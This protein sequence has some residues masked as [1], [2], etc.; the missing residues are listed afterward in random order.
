GVYPMDGYGQH[1]Y[2][3]GWELAPIADI[4]NCISNYHGFYVAYEGTGTSKG[5]WVTEFGWD[6]NY[7]QQRNPTWSWAKCLSVQGSNMTTSLN[8][9]NTQ[10]AGSYVKFASWYNWQDGGGAD[11]GLF[12][13][14]G[15]PTPA[16]TNF[17]N[18]AHYE[19]RTAINNGGTDTAILNYY[20]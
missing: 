20:N 7:L 6:A 4:Q 19:G 13:T 9:Y 11:F 5:T 8:A 14:S 15:N 18:E 1:L 3:D 10:G 12:D 2:I 17:S 16:Y